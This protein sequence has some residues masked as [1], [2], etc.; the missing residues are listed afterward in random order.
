M[1]KQKIYYGDGEGSIY[2]DEGKSDYG[3]R[4]I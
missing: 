1:D 4:K 3:K 2:T